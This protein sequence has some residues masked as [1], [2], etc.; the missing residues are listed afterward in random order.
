MLRGLSLLFLLALCVVGCGRLEESPAQRANTL[1]ITTSRIRGFDPAK[2]ADV[3]SALAIA[4]VYEGLLQI[5][6][7]DRPYCLEPLLATAMPEKSEDGL[8]YTFHIRPGIY[9]SDD[10]CFPGGKGRELVAEDFVYSI[11]RLA[12][13][14]VGSTGWWAFEGRIR[15]LNDFRDASAGEEPTDY[16]RPVEGLRATDR[17]TLVIELIHPY[18][19]FLW[20]LAMH[21]GSALPREAVERYGERFGSHPVGTGPYRLAH[22][23]RNYRMIFERNPTW[24]ETGRTDSYPTTGEA[25]DAERGLLADAGKPLPFMDRIVAYVV[26]DAATQWMMFLNGQLDESGISRDNWDVVMDKH[27]QLLPALRERGIEMAVAPQL[28]I[29]YLGFNMDDPI[30]GTNLLLRRAITCAFNTEEWIQLFNGRIRRALGPIPS[31]LPG[32]DPD[33]VPF[34]FDLAR[35]KQL[36]SEAGYPDGR[37]P[38]T[39]RRLELTLELGSAG[40]IEARQAAEMVAAFFDR[41]GIALKLSFNNTPAYFEKLERRQAQ[42]FM[43]GW[44]GDYP[45]AENFL[46]CFY[47]PNASPGPNRANYHNAEYDRLYDTIRV[48]DDS[49]ERTALYARMARLLIDD[50]PWVFL[51][52]PLVYTLYNQRLHN[53]KPHLF[54]YGMEKYYRLE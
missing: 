23:R 54:P 39:D 10:D 22:W 25:G 29:N 31:A 16:D 17:Y 36:L 51:S 38:A 11:K 49:P 46:Q 19:Q 41:L 8:R 44:L 47:G 32:F 42:M 30:L 14:K 37:D 9:F 26:A 28:R 18:P 6:Y 13:R 48:M 35:A 34:P 7:L 53:R 52:E 50:C 1:Y 5:S 2:A 3:P 27:R 4:R 24:R 33:Y 40:D 12:D 15:G 21:Y 20:V 43:L 45:D